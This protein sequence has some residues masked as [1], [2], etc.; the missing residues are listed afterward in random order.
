[1]SGTRAPTLLHANSLDP[2]DVGIF[3]WDAT[4]ATDYLVSSNGNQSVEWATTSRLRPA[5]TAV[6]SQVSLTKR[7]M[8]WL[9]AAPS[10]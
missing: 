4:V 3:E 6:G 7:I 5:N 9:S 8:A 1:M 10:L 2:E